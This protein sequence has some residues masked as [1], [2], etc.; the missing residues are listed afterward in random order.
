MSEDGEIDVE[1]DDVAEF[2]D[3]ADGPDGRVSGKA[4]VLSLS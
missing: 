1:S 2:V 3:G 4:I